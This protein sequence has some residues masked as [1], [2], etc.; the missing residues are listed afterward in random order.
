MFTA[1][2]AVCLLGFLGGDVSSQ[3]SEIPHSTGI[4]GINHLSL[5]DHQ[6]SFNVV[7]TLITVVNSVVVK[8]KRGTWQS[9]YNEQRQPNITVSN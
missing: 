2:H 3:L 1:S 7:V 6:D 4:N 9:T 5:V 8:P